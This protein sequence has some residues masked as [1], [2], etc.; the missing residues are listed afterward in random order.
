MQTHKK[1]NHNIA[2]IALGASHPDYSPPR[3]LQKGFF[4][5]I[6]DEIDGETMKYKCR[7]PTLVV[8]GDTRTR[9]TEELDLSKGR[10]VV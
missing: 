2:H 1:G 7:V 5:S 3:L 9:S 8:V 6:Q 4:E 10:R